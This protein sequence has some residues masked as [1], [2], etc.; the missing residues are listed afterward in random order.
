LSKSGVRLED[1]AKQLALL[2]RI[3]QCLMRMA[4]IAE[5]RLRHS[6]FPGLF[7]GLENSH[8]TALDVQRRK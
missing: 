7:P 2:D 3:I 4:A 5:S 6:A 8:G 1:I